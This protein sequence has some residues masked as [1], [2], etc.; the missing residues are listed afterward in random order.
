MVITLSNYHFEATVISRGKGRSLAKSL[1][2]IT[3][4]RVRDSYLG[5]TYYSKRDDV[6]MQKIYLPENVPTHF[7]NLQSLCDEMDKCEKRCDARTARAFVGSL[8]NELPYDSL[9]HI[10]SFFIKEC[11][12]S[13]GICAIAAIHEGRNDADPSKN[14]P[15][16]HIITATRTADE[17]GFSRNKCREYDNK[18]YLRYWRKQWELAQN[19]AYSH[20]GRDERVSCKS[21][22]DRDIIKLKPIRHRSRIDWQKEL[23][24]LNTLKDDINRAIKKARQRKAERE[25][26]ELSRQRSR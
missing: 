11:F 14:N 21:Y 12:T 4:E 25:R 15:H 10:V 13:R 7:N 3:G 16:V 26:D 19:R 23:E 2:Y 9:E 5:K 22:K 8:P 17:N 24:G 1:N 18:E 6:L 20:N